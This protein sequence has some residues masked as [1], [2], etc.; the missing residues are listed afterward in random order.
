MEHGTGI[1][2]I[3]GGACGG[4]PG[5]GRAEGRRTH[6]LELRTSSLD[7]CLEFEG[8]E[9]EAAELAQR[10]RG[11]RLIF[12]ERP[13]SVAV[14]DVYWPNLVEEQHKTCRDSTN[15]EGKREP[16]SKEGTA[17]ML[18]AIAMEH[19]AEFARAV[20]GGQV[21]WRGWQALALMAEQAAEAAVWELMRDEEPCASLQERARACTR[22]EMA[23]IRLAGQGG[24]ARALLDARRRA[25]EEAAK[26]GP[27]KAEKPF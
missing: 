27:P 18:S 11:C 16:E 7:V 9:A 8:F 14:E 25:I 20:A 4:V 23:G 13:R 21:G 17:E 6:R 24:R 15:P 12:P 1:S 5:G 3:G 10:L 19:G 2:G 26:V 22:V